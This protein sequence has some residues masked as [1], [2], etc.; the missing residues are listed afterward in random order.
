MRILF[1][2]ILGLELGHA[3]DVNLSPASA[4]LFCWGRDNG[5]IAWQD[6]VGVQT[7]ESLM[8]HGIVLSF[9]VALLCACQPNTGIT[10]WSDKQ[11]TRPPQEL[12]PAKGHMTSAGP[13]AQLAKRAAEPM[14]LRELASTVGASC[15]DPDTGA[16]C[17]GGDYDVELRPDCGPDGLFAG[18]SDP[19]GALL[20]DKAPPEDT[21]RRATLAQGQIVCV[22]A[23]ARA[24]DSASYYYVVAISASDV[25]ACKTNAVCKRY[26][27]RKI[28]WH[29]PHEEANCREVSKG[30]FEGV[31]AAGWVRE[32]RLEIFSKT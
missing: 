8:R 22:E 11:S 3:R 26:G 19:K 18:V 7:W 27:D 15:D 5:A 24:G 21:V 2:R 23:I 25:E 10:T 20:I 30:R 14:T 17:T 13:T 31:C 32:S 12:A 4:G 29:V 16:N 6:A 1:C 9:T 28:D